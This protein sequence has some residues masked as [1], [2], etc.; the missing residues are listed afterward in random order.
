MHSGNEKEGVDARDVL[1]VVLLGLTISVCLVGL[2][3][4]EVKVKGDLSV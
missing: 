2:W 3:K 1:E 4:R